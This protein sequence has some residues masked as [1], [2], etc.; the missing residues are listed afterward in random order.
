MY[1]KLKE[2]RI[3][4]R[5]LHTFVSCEFCSNLIRPRKSCKPGEKTYKVLQIEVENPQKIFVPKETFYKNKFFCDILQK[6]FTVSSCVVFEKKN[7]LCCTFFTTLQNLFIPETRDLLANTT[8]TL[9]PPPFRPFCTSASYEPRKHTITP[10][11]RTNRN[12]KHG[13]SQA[14]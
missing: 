13:Q 14:S 6:C 7:Y 10:P 5:I 12:A 9:V 2:D 3:K 4:W 1:E 11:A 8:T